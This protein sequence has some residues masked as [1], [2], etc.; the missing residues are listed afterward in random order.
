MVAGVTISG[1][2]TSAVTPASNAT[3]VVYSHGKNGRGAFLMGS[4]TAFT[5]PTG[6][7]ELQNLPD[8]SSPGSTTLSRRTFVSRSRTDETSTAGEFDDLVAWMPAPVL[9]AKLLA[10]GLW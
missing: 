6:N 5:A 1:C 8:S 7:D 10:A 9:A 2:G 3:F 4:S